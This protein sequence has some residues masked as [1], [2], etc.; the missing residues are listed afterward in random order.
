MKIRALIS[1]WTLILLVVV[2][3]GARGGALPPEGHPLEFIDTG[4]ENASPLWY[5]V[6]VDGTVDVHLM[7]DHERASPNRAAGHFHFRLVAP[8]GSNLTIEFKNLENVYNGRAASVAGELRAAVVSTDGRNWRPVALEALEKNR[9]RLH[10]TMPAPALYVAR[11]EPYR[12]SDLDRWLAEIRKHPAVTITPIGKTPEGRELEIVQVGRTDAPYRVFLRARAHAWE[13]GG[14]WVVEGLVQRLLRNDEEAARFLE[15]YVVYVLP[16]AN[17]DG[18]ARGRTRFNVRGKDLNRN[19]DRP[20]HPEL[21]PENHALETWLQAKIAAGKAPHLA[22]EL[23]NDGNGKLH[24]SRPPV[25]N[26]DRYL[27]RMKI[28]EELLRA[29]TWFTEGSTEAGFRNSGTLGD[30]WF[31]RFGIDALVHEFNVNQIQVKGQR[32]FPSAARWRE[33][34]AGLAQVFFD[35]FERVK[36]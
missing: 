15:R 3:A 7:Y 19:W 28:L 26:L 24:I 6:A 2:P 8:R 14:N 31:E 23:H 13:P 21:A 4:F 5:E 10:V 33:Y 30:G 35:Y 22:I 20:A 25:P 27:K 1:S 32:D 12:L 34:G 9:V 16:L 36:P 11:V 17:K 29:H 18:V